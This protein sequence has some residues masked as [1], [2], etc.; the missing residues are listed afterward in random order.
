[1]FENLS[2]RLGGTVKKLRGQ[3]GLSE[4]NI[5]DTLRIRMACEADVA[6]PVVRGF[7]DSVKQKALG[8]EFC[9]AFPWSVLY[10]DRS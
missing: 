3:A 9:K 2:G 1:M 5:Q 4:E 6:L 10:Q 7:I 8:K